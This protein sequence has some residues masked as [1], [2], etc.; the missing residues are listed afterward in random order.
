MGGLQQRENGDF[1]FGICDTLDTPVQLSEKMTP[2]RTILAH[3]FRS[4]FARL[5][6]VTVM[7]TLFFMLSEKM[8]EVR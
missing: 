2:V 4:F 5:Q 7:C 3:F 8:A 6:L 1:V